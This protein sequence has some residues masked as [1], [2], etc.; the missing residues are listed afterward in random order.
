MNSLF[1]LPSKNSKK[2]LIELFCIVAL[3]AAGI[4]FTR[5]FSQVVEIHPHDET[6]YHVAAKEGGRMPPGW[7]PVYISYLRFLY[8]FESDSLSVYYANL[9]ILTIALSVVGFLICRALG[10]GLFLSFAL[11]GIVLLADSNWLLTPKVNQFNV[12][13]LGLAFLLATAVKKLSVEILILLL[14][15]SL[16]LRLDNIFCIFLFLVFLFYRNFSQPKN[17]LKGSASIGG[18]LLGGAAVFG[19]LLATWED[20]FSEGRAWYA[21]LD[22]AHWRMAPAL[23]RAE[24]VNEFLGGSESVFQAIQNNPALVLTNGALNLWDAFVDFL[25]S[26]VLHNHLLVFTKGFSWLSSLLDLVA[27][28]G[29]FLILGRVFS[30]RE[31]ASFPRMAE[32]RKVFYVLLFG[33]LLK[34]FITIF[35]LKAWTRYYLEFW[36]FSLIAV[37]VFF[38]GREFLKKLNKFS[39]LIPLLFAALCYWAAPQEDRSIVN[40]MAEISSFNERPFWNLVNQIRKLEG[41]GRCISNGTYWITFNNFI[42]FRPHEDEVGSE[43][44]WKELISKE[45]IKLIVV[46]PELRVWSRRFG[47]YDFVNELELKPQTFGFDEIQ[48]EGLPHFKAFRAKRN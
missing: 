13:Y 15:P 28:G 31:D 46:D 44:K 23:T 11:A 4:G 24:F 16:Y 20:P 1:K 19:F 47:A 43:I 27:M 12:L 45:E 32:R 2:F 8:L 18:V 40:R 29:V 9:S 10:L 14:I 36:F 17:W 30:I 35:L 3:V 26:L 7:A 48:V 39:L 42:C 38:Q 41:S 22:H 25:L 34:G 33:C 6:Y 5:N 37:C 21:F